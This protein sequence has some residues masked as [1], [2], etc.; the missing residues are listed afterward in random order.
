MTYAFISSGDPNVKPMAVRPPIET[1]LRTTDVDICGDAV[2]ALQNLNSTD[3]DGRYFVVLDQYSLQPDRGCLIGDTQSEYYV[4]CSFGLSL[5]VVETLRHERKKWPDLW[6][7]AALAGGTISPLQGAKDNA[8]D[9]YQSITDQE[10]VK[11]TIQTLLQRDFGRQNPQSD[12][13]YAV[14][15][16][17]DIPHAVS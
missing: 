12:R 6:L 16:T 17:V 14:L 7:D 15:C 4:R 2:I 9:K 11:Q 1:A 3:I 8:L 10:D 5:L 13:P